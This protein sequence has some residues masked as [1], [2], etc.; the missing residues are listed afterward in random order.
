M[1]LKTAIYKI[2]ITLK[3][4]YKICTKLKNAASHVTAVGTLINKRYYLQTLLAA[5]H[6]TNGLHVTSK[7]L[8]LLGDTLF[9]CF[10]FYYVVL[11]TKY[12]KRI[13]VKTLKFTIINNLLL[14]IQMIPF[15]GSANTY[16]YNLNLVSM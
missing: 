5:S 15:F 16:R 14:M 7:F 13:M 1:H 4:C 11:L 2:T 12:F 3:Q 9:I 6:I 8:K 10:Y